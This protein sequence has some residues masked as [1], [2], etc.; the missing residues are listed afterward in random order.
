MKK[1][2]FAVLTVLA[3]LAAV[4]ACIEFV[5]LLSG[6]KINTSAKFAQNNELLFVLGFAVY[7]AVHILLYRPVFMHVMAHELTH[8]LWAMFFGGKTK[9]LEVS[10]TG[11]RVLINKSNFLISL[12]PYFFPLYT[13]LFSA[14]YI[15]AADKF[16]PLIAFFVGASL[17]FHVALT[18]YSLTVNQSDLKEDSNVVFSAA[19]II[20]MNT[21]V[22]GAV[23]AMIA[24]NISF[25]PFFMESIKGTL[26]IVKWIFVTLNEAL[27]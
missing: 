24:D 25:M 9:K 15:I 18:L 7:L 12:A 10:R 4:S 20:F 3:V 21:L 17:S 8:A 5:K 26:G 11:G 19:F 2:I 27:K 16:R 14:I 22:I 13:V 6:F 23:L 1:I